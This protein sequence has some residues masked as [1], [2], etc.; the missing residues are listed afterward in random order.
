[1]NSGPMLRSPTLRC[2]ILEAIIEAEQPQCYLIVLGVIASGCFHRVAKRVDMLNQRVDEM[3]PFHART[4]APFYDEIS[5]S[6]KPNAAVVGRQGGRVDIVRHS[7]LASNDRV[8]SASDNRNGDL[9][10]LN[11]SS[12]GDYE[13]R[14]DGRL[15]RRPLRRGDI[16]FL[17]CGLTTELTY[18]ASNSALLV[19]F[20]GEILRQAALPGDTPPLSPR[21]SESNRRLAQLIMLAESEL[22][23]PGFAAE[24]LIEGVIQAIAALLSRQNGEPIDRDAARIHISPARLARVIDYVD[25]NLHREV[26]LKDLAEVAQF[27]PFHFSRIFK[28]ATGESPYQF[29]SARRLQ[30]AMQLLEDGSLPLAELALCCGFSSQAH[31]TTA[32]SKAKGVSPGRYRRGLGIAND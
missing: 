29:V 31:F 2:I 8:S 25:A 3:R 10:V 21:Y 20:P 5:F 32:F 13:R 1:M 7:G 30:R 17:P 15:I 23:S 19:S 28:R 22:R 24:M 9:I 27:S 26:A 12:G 6:A 16:S 18:P 14:G 11:L 4:G